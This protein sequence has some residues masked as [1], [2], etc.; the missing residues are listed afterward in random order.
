MSIES[1]RDAKRNALRVF[2]DSK[3]GRMDIN[4]TQTYTDLVNTIDYTNK[5]N[6]LEDFN[7]NLTEKEHNLM[8][9]SKDKQ[10]YKNAISNIKPRL[11][12][13][14]LYDVAQ[15]NNYLVV[16]TSNAAEIYLGYFTK[17]GDGAAD[18]YPLA[19]FTKEEVYELAIELGVNQRIIDAKPSADLFE[20]QTDEEQL[21]LTYKTIDKFLNGQEID[22]QDKEKI[23]K[24]HNASQ[25]KLF[26][27]NK[28][29]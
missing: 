23:E 11:R 8:K 24:M 15:Y 1:S 19:N 9:S 29:D 12:M 26:K 2:E 27:L 20:G 18:L 13:I 6:D 17:W 4:L 3:I 14:T 5:Y 22:K 25:H 28:P 10:S 7:N 21:G 16:G